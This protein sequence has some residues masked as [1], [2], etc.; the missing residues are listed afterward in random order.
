MNFKRKEAPLTVSC[1]KK[2]EM[3]IDYSRCGTVTI[4]MFDFLSEMLKELKTD[5]EGVSATTAP[6]HLIAVNE[7]VKV[8]DEPTAQIFHHNVAK[9][10][11]C[12]KVLVLT[13]GKG[14]KVTG[15]KT[16]KKVKPMT[17]K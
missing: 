15:L 4:T 7:N 9:L 14:E 6:L 2:L 1:G 8:L 12:A 16:R 11:F 5:M 3:M 17:Q 13:V 10:L